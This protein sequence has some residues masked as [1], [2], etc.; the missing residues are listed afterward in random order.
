MLQELL[1]WVDT[2]IRQ[3][4]SLKPGNA[5]DLQSILAVAMK[6]KNSILWAQILAMLDMKKHVHSNIFHG[7]KAMTLQCFNCGNVGHLQRDC[8]KDSSMQAKRTM[9]AT[10]DMR[11]TTGDNLPMG[12]DPQMLAVM[13]QKVGDSMSSAV[14]K[15]LAGRSAQGARQQVAMLQWSANRPLPQ[16]VKTKP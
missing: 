15:V 5:T 3:Q 13:A 1:N 14:Q 12:Y 6:E 10:L 11:N 4:E 8:P 16:H 7:G 2:N 9:A